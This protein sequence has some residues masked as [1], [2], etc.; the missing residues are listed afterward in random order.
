MTSPSAITI[1]TMAEAATTPI[2]VITKSSAKPE[3]APA[4]LPSPP[5]T[6]STKLASISTSGIASAVPTS[7]KSPAF[8]SELPRSPMSATFSLLP[9]TPGVA[10]EG[11]LKTPIT[12]PVA[13]MDF[14][15][16]AI[17][18][19][20]DLKSPKFLPHHN[21]TG[22]V[23]AGPSSPMNPQNNPAKRYRASISGP[24]GGMPSPG[25]LG[26]HMQALAKPSSSSSQTKGPY[27]P[28]HSS[29]LSSARSSTSSLSSSLSS[30]SSSSNS[31]PVS[32]SSSGTSVEREAVVAESSKKVVRFAKPDGK[33]P[34]AEE[35]EEGEGEEEEEEEEEGDEDE[36]M[37]EVKRVRKKTL[38]KDGTVTIKQVVTT[39][40][41][42][43]PR[44]SLMPAPKGKRRRIE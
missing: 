7:L 5:L 19:P 1:T 2:P 15:K 12:P 3:S 16:N 20:S 8:P 24:S 4:A 11:A 26:A 43:K 10:G 28:T 39:T 31:E 13:Y 9:H 21:P 34:D 25:L 33:A 18:S 36:P 35:V 38:N 22:H 27:T 6:T 29:A 44:M 14:L 37:E 23:S 40:V 17:A 32:R 30:S 42:F 41:T